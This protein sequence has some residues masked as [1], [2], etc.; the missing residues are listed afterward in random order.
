MSYSSFSLHVSISHFDA[1]LAF[2]DV[3]KSI[4]LERTNFVTRLRHGTCCIAS[5]VASSG[6]SPENIE[7]CSSASS[8]VLHFISDMAI[9]YILLPTVMEQSQLVSHFLGYRTLKTMDMT[10]RVKT[11]R[12]VKKKPEE[13]GNGEVWSQYCI[14]FHWVRNSSLV[15]TRSA[16]IINQHGG[17]TNVWDWKEVLEA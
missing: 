2:S 3:Y 13:D 1:F 10:Q 17:R 9:M 4:A 14:K 8:V 6:A 15:S 12:P 5:D 7:Y 11:P 16:K